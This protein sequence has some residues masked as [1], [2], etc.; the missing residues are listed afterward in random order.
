MSVTSKPTGVSDDTFIELTKRHIANNLESIRRVVGDR[1][2]VVVRDEQAGEM[3][4][5]SS[6][7]P[8]ESALLA[9]EWPEAETE[10]L[11]SP[12]PHG[13]FIT[14]VVVPSGSQM[15]MCGIRRTTALESVGDA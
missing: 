2:L 4:Y 1:V 11:S 13:A 14:V 9:D 15:F 6:F 3:S 8:R 7:V 10:M 12:P 5:S